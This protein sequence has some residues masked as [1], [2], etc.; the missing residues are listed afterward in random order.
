MEPRQPEESSHLQ[1]CQSDR[2]LLS[3]NESE[4]SHKRVT[5]RRRTP[6]RSRNLDTHLAG[7]FAN[8][9]GSGSPTVSK[10]RPAFQAYAPP[11]FHR[12]RRTAWPNMSDGFANA[13]QPR[14]WR[15]A[16]TAGPRDRTAR[17]QSRARPICNGQSG[18]SSWPI[19]GPTSRTTPDPSVASPACNLFAIAQLRHPPPFSDAGTEPGPDME[20]ARPN[21]GPKT[22]GRVFH[23]LKPTRPK[24]FHRWEP[25]LPSARC[26]RPLVRGRRD[27]L[28]P[29]PSLRPTADPPREPKRHYPGH[30]VGGD[31]EAELVPLLHPREQ[32][33][34]D[35]GTPTLL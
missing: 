32:L 13:A 3:T 11:C 15:P 30:V 24:H 5:A 9:A 29:Q 27:T 17:K 7:W 21:S 16:P 31:L 20:P 25:P 2:T 12:E 18:P 34:L 4:S 22:Q 14:P 26:H 8:V 19:S 28:R 1:Y 10:M 33:R 23:K 6:H 35:T